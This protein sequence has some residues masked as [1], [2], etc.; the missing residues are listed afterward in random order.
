M[1]RVTRVAVDRSCAICERTLLMGEKAIRFSPA[2][3]GGFVDVCPL[4]AEAAVEH[5]WLRE[6][7]PT[8]PTVPPERKRR[9]GGWS[10]SPPPW[11]PPTA[12]GTKVPHPK[13]P[14]PPLP[15]HAH[16]S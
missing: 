2:L 11:A 13:P 3:G 16:D 7:A 4:C 12:D 6:G 5:G 8:T 10:A 9:S 1:T 15:Q 14:P